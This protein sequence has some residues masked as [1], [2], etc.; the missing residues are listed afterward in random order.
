VLPIAII[1]LDLNMPKKNGVEA[2]KE[3]IS[4]YDTLE[5]P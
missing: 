2:I 5:L 1:I 4:F 3:I